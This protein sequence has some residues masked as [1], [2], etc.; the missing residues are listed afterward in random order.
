MAIGVAGILM[1]PI[2]KAELA[3]MVR[4]A[5]DKAK[6]AEKPADKEV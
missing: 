3:R 5:L 2:I 1:K 4:E 6:T